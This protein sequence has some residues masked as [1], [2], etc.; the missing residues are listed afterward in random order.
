[1][2]NDD[3]SNF[4]CTFVFHKKK[5]ASNPLKNF[6]MNSAKFCMNYN[7]TKLLRNPVAGPLWKVLSEYE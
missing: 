7:F 1:M 2:L 5:C 4:F 6:I 3:D